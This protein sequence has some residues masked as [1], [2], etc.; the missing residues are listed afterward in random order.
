[1]IYSIFNLFL[2]HFNQ[3]GRLLNDRIKSSACAALRR[4]Q[5]KY[6]RGRGSGWQMEA[7]SY[8]PYSCITPEERY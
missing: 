1:M 3:D 2:I 6:C 5:C 8:G 7:Y 4:D